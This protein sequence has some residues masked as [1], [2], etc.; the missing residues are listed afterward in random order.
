MIRRAKTIR[1]PRSVQLARAIAQ[2]R[3]KARE[4]GRC[5][6]VYAARNPSAVIMYSALPFGTVPWQPLAIVT[7][8]IG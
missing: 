5:Y 3:R 2:A 4:T 6:G 7:R 8:Q 1:R